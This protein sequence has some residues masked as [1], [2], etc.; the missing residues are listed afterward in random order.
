LPFRKTW[1]MD[2]SPG[3][4]NNDSC[5]IRSSF[6]PSFRFCEALGFGV[7]VSKNPSVI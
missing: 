3:S 7:P 2:R 4:L 5:R 1:T 6:S